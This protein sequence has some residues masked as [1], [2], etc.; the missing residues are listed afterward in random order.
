[1]GK[2]RSKDKR[3]S[4][5]ASE[6]Q[7]SDRAKRRSRRLQSDPSSAHANGLT[8]RDFVKRVTVAGALLGAPLV[9]P[10]ALGDDYEFNAAMLDPESERTGG[11]RQMLFFNLSHLKGANTTHHLHLGGRKYPLTRVQ[12]RPNVLKA[13]RRN[14][15]F[16]RSVPDDQIT[17]H[18]V[19]ETAQ[20]VV[21]LGYWSSNENPADGSWEMTG[22][23]MDIPQSALAAAYLH[24]RQSTPTGPLPLSNKRQ[25]Y[26]VRA[27]HTLRDL[28][29]EAMLVDPTSFAEAVVGVHPDIL[30]VV[31]SVA[32]R[33][34]TKYV[35][36]NGEAQQLG[37]ILKVMGPAVPEGTRNISNTLPWATLQPVIDEKTGK[38]Y[39]KSDGLNAY[40]PQWNNEVGQLAA[41]SVAT[42]HQ[43]VKADTAF[44]V[45]VTAY[46]LND[47]NR[48]PPD[49]TLL[50]KCWAR[51]DGIPTV[52]VVTGVGAGSGPTM[53]FVHKSTHTG[54]VVVDPSFTTAPDGK[55]I[56]ITLD[57]VSNWFLR[58]LGVWVQ[59]FD[60]NGSAI[61]S[62]NL[63]PDTYP[64]SDP[65]FDPRS[66]DKPDA[67]FLGIVPP[68]FTVSAVPMFAGSFSP[69]IYV[70]T[71][72]QRVRIL[73]T[74]LGL[75]GSPPED[76]T[77]IYTHGACMTAAFNYGVVAMM[78]FAGASEWS[79][80]YKLSASIGGGALATAI[81]TIIGGVIDQKGFIA[82]LGTF[83]MGFMKVLLQAGNNKVITALVEAI[84]EELV[85]VEIVDTIPIAGQIAQA[86]A[87]AAGVIQLAESTIEI[88]I[89]PP[90]AAYECVFTHD[91]S[92][93]FMAGSQFPALP[94]AYTLYYKVSY[95][96]DDGTAHTQDAVDI[97]PTDTSFPIT[98]RS[99]PYGGQVNVSIGFYAR[100]NTTPPGQ[101]DWCAGYGTTGLVSNTVAQIPP[102]TG[103]QGFPITFVKIPITGTTRY[104]HTRKTALDA[105]GNHRWD[106][107]ADG[108]HAPPYIQP[109]DSQVPSLGDF[110]SITVRQATAEQQGYVGYAWEAFSTGVNG[111]DSRSP[112]QYD[113]MANLNTDAA[114][115]GT[116]AQN[117]Y[118]NS[119]ALCGFD[120][121]VQMGYN[122]LTHKSV[123][124]YLDTTTGMIRPVS[125]DPP[126]FAGRTSNQ[127]FG[128]L[129]LDSTRCL[130]HPSG[131][132][133][134]INNAHHRIE[135]L[136]L[137][138][139]KQPGSSTP[140]YCV[141]TDDNAQAYY[142][143]RLHAGKGMRPGLID[144]P[145]AA[146]ISPD[147]VILVLEDNNNRI[148]AFDVGGNPVPY[149]THQNPPYYLQLTT[150]IDNDY[151]DLAVEF[152]G[153]L[154]VL[155][156]DGSNVHRLDIYHPSQTG[157]RPICTTMNVNA[158]KL[159]VDFWRGVYTLNYEVLRLPSGDIPS[160]TEPSVSLWVPPPPG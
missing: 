146:S 97:N 100:H 32:A 151:L 92:V 126:G 7:S 158:A 56:Q 35:S 31:P 134:S 19:I 58:Y 128:M 14:N 8:R 101:N 99:I 53:T 30:S 29:E 27:A 145:I 135:T 93:T 3:L 132:I 140:S 50:G 127:S 9:A 91:L 94:G 52:N 136:K 41:R 116:N 21:R 28:S 34:R 137:P 84:T 44:G 89:A 66:Q 160:F 11:K 5:K 98:F 124:M 68:P 138:T 48:R 47:P 155:S 113:Q 141:Q 39:R 6:Q 16:L 4:S 60:A 57:N 62:K 20:D 43:P 104:I 112:G 51:R 149:F 130:L 72:A 45:D 107:D 95:L 49:A 17:H 131:H 150:T 105:N 46:N 18:V 102:P 142:L 87:I 114:N 125:L 38:P 117:G 121:G 159:T 106:T 54:L 24:A 144:S 90:A 156:K 26:G 77:G 78:M 79:A 1:M 74:G 61:L 154:Y 67:I 88:M 143:A 36:H 80:A 122:L 10:N 139:C 59:F 103:R 40:H 15:E 81:S 85:E 2:E 13:Y 86:V 73:Y 22:M 152:S 123:N 71:D 108:T 120:P 157:T 42:L 83:T 110:R 55:R 37:A 75:G 118:T 96:F 23:H 33:I 148:Q 153:Y 111:C 147:G 12:D 69:K 119:I 82:Q 25:N 70:P 63:P 65:D 76:P 133:V 109:P 129:N 115:N 64:V